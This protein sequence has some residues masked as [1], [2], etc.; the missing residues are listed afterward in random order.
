MNIPLIRTYSQQLTESQLRTPHETVAWLGAV[1]AQNY[2]M[3]KWAVGI[4]SKSSVSDV[5]AAFARGEIL[6]THVMRPTWHWVTAENIRWMCELSKRAIKAAAAH[7]DRQLEID[8]KLFSKVNHLLETM[9]RDNNHLTRIEI[10]EQLNVN[11]IKTDAARMIHFMLRAEVEGIVCS[12]INKGKN[13]T[14][15][16]ID[17]RVEPVKKRNRDEALAQLARNYFQSHS[18]AT[19]LDFAWW[20]GLSMADS[21]AALNFIDNELT[22]ES[23]E[24]RTY[25]I[26]KSLNADLAHTEN[27]Q[28]LPAFD[29]YIIA[30]RDRTTVIAAEYQPKAFTKN[31]IFF[32]V[33]LYNGKAIGVWNKSQKNNDL[34]FSY[35]WFEKDCSG[36]KSLLERVEN[37]YREFED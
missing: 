11:G 10:S 32:P 37:R 16:L 31:G 30:Y 6:R 3:S 14:Y 8:E 28:L 5:E 24:N 18:P 35:D 29:E 21:R 12:G 7:R 2:E 4:R 23:V 9:L 17:E 34:R 25:F 22:K 13:Q 36:P 19:V 27:L 26:H 20:S 33:V 1:Q 15:A